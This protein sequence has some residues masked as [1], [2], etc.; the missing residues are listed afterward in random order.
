VKAHQRL[1]RL[2]RKIHSA[3]E[4]EVG[5]LLGELPESIVRY[6]KTYK[7][8]F[9]N[10]AR[11]T[12]R[13]S[14]ELL[15][16]RMREA[17]VV[18]VADYHTLGQAQRTALRLLQDSF[19]PGEEWYLG[20]E[21]VPSNR[22]A[23]LDAY[24]AGL[25][26][27]VSFLTKIRYF[28][29]WG[30]AWEQYAPLIEWARQNG[31]KLLALNRPKELPLYQWRK[32]GAPQERDLNERDRWAAGI[33]SD[34]FE[35]KKARVFVLY[36]ELHVGDLHLPTAMREISKSRLGTAL[37]CVT[38]HQNNDALYWKLAKRG[39]EHLTDVLEMSSGHFHVISSTPWNKLQSVVSWAEGLGTSMERLPRTGVLAPRAT[40]ISNS[41]GFEDD[42]WLCDLESEALSRMQSYG[43]AMAE[44]LKLPPPSFEAVGLHSV[45]SAD[46]VDELGRDHG[47][48]RQAR[49]MLHQLVLKNARFYLHWSRTLYLGTPSA[50]GAAEMAAIV[51]GR[52]PVRSS[53][54]FG[55]STD[56]FFQALL[57]QAFGFFGSLLVNPRRK[58][59]LPQDHLNE[60]LR[61]RKSE[62]GSLEASTRLFT[63]IALEE[64]SRFL[65]RIR[66]MQ[67]KGR[68]QMPAVLAMG[69]IAEL[70]TEVFASQSVERWLSLWFCARNLG[71]ILGKLL[72]EAVLHGRVSLEQVR[73][74]AWQASD[75][76]WRP[77]EVRYWE[78]VS[79]VADQT[80]PSSK[81]E[82]I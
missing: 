26:D 4:S 27:T 63:V 55:D 54:F 17:D 52:G 65:E 15:K 70:A 42:E 24:S 9:K 53:S 21:F 37:K 59:D 48:S 31:V 19:R 51:L 1:L 44:F 40:Q 46:F 5:R 38:I 49:R 67:G 76:R 2:Q 45:Y 3:L 14:R 12:R 77:A 32:K 66:R 20:L 39:P 73:E 64:Q 74:L 18:L 11:R 78:W 41:L 75:R 33:V 35:K 56:T 28:E 62:P 80:V 34:L 79:V 8:S 25:L 68:R 13:S 30:F 50:N 29:E 6:E 47:L 58:C 82:M 72:H 10:I 60:F 71:Q 61:L 57:D 36:G 7:E 22:Q 16:R 23:E 43:E 81:R 69:G